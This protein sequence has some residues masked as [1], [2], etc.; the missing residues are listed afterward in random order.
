MPLEILNGVFSHI[1]TILFCLHYNSI[2]LGLK[3]SLIIYKVLCIFWQKLLFISI[4]IWIDGNVF[5][6]EKKVKLI[7][8]QSAPG[9]FFKLTNEILSD[10]NH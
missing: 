7:F 9:S 8:H 10:F 4:L 1:G 3:S 5:V 6:V 2:N